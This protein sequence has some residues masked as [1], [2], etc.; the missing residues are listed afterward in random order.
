MTRE[1]LKPW[2][3]LCKK[4]AYFVVERFSDMDKPWVDVLN[5]IDL[6]NKGG[7]YESLPCM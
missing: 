2:S 1:N 4:G 3:R 6:F 7:E 5:K